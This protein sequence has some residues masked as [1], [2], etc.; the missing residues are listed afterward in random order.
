MVDKKDK[1]NKNEASVY[2]FTNDMLDKRKK[3]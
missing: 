1:E 2:M 3:Q